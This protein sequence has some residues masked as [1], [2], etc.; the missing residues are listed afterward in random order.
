MIYWVQEESTLYSLSKKFNLWEILIKKNVA[1]IH[2][3]GKGETL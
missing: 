2:D 3:T 1:A